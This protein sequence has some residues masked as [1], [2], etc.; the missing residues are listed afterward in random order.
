MFTWLRIAIALGAITIG[1]LIFLIV[2]R[3]F[4]SSQRTMIE[5]KRK[6][7]QLVWVAR[8]CATTRDFSNLPA[9]LSKVLIKTVPPN[10]NYVDKVARVSYKWATDHP[11]EVYQWYAQYYEQRPQSPNNGLEVMAV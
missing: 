1:F 8:S 2:K 6:V 10:G 11:D 4:N 7:G 3:L 9:G 5:R